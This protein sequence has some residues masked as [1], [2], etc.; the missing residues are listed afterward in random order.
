MS[1][2][3]NKTLYRGDSFE[4]MKNIEDNSVDAVITDP[5]YN[6]T[7]CEW[8]KVIDFEKLWLH[9]K[10]ITKTNVPIIFFGQQPFTSQLINSNLKMFKYCWV[11]EKSNVTGFLNANHRPLLSYEDII[12]FSEGNAGAGGKEKECRIFHKA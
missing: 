9:I 7:R 2:K 1:D 8:D 12:V 3:S 11:W 4:I 10:R 5:P 6:T